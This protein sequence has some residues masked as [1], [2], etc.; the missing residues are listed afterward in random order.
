MPIGR[1]CKVLK[2][3]GDK[4]KVWDKLPAEGRPEQ[5]ENLSTDVI[6]YLQ[7]NFDWPFCL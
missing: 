1:A 6:N 7:D 5:P 4:L 3:F 2:D